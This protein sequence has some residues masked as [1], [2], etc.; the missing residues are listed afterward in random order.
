[1]SA[2]AVF[3]IR[4]Y[5]DV[6]LC[7]SMF[8]RSCASDYLPSDSELQ[9]FA[10]V[11]AFFC[12]LDNLFFCFLFCVR[13][14]FVFFSSFCFVFWGKVFFSFFFFF[15]LFI[16]K[17]LWHELRL[18]WRG[19]LGQHRATHAVADRRSEGLGLFTKNRNKYK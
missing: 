12:A 14:F 16:L 6:H 15:F 7:D 19:V 18:Q 1:M 8:C 10:V 17:S 3:H 4:E 9:F 2:L 5:F 13:F 11:D